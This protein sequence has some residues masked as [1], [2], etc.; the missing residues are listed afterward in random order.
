M[1]IYCLL[2]R[3]ESGICRKGSHSTPQK[4]QFAEVSG[5]TSWKVGC[6]GSLVLPFPYSDLF[7]LAIP[8][9]WGVGIELCPHLLGLLSAVQL[10]SPKARISPPAP[11]PPALLKAR[12][13]RGS[14]RTFG[15]AAR[16][17][18]MFPGLTCVGVRRPRRSAASLLP[19]ES[20]SSQATYASCCRMGSL[21]GSR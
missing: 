19:E 4:V 11:F 7:C 8:F 3:C 10:S 5:R 18:V 12:Q 2:S 14:K 16:L 6:S 15:S 1:P 13:R 21:L 17:Y 9:W 20:L